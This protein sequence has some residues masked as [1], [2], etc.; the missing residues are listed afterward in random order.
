MVLPIGTR[1]SSASTCDPCSR[2][3]IDHRLG[4]CEEVAAVGSSLGWPGSGDLPC[5]ALS[6]LIA[7]GGG[8][9]CHP[10][11]SVASMTA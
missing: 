8:R 10:S 7:Q 9:R 11:L 3:P 5:P 4:C 2:T 1:W 6:L